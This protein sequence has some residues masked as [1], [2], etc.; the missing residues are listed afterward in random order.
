MISMLEPVPMLLGG[1]LQGR[2]DQSEAR[3]PGRMLRSCGK[4]VVPKPLDPASV[5]A[6]PPLNMQHTF[7][8]SSG[9][10]R[11]TVNTESLSPKELEKDGARALE[12]PTAE[13]KQ[14]M[15]KSPDPTR[16]ARHVATSLGS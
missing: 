14:K 15:T 10:C 8:G 7:L 12:V 5:S 9:Y 2:P 6:A 16:R 4:H 11:R 13:R 3:V 1:E